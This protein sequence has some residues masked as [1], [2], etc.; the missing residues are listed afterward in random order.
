MKF[1]R[2]FYFS[3]WDHGFIFSILWFGK[4]GNFFHLLQIYTKKRKISNFFWVAKMQKKFKKKKCCM[5][6]SK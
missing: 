4:F 5:Q 2:T 6:Y 3:T 1:S